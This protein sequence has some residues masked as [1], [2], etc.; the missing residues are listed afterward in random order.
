MADLGG[1]SSGGRVDGGVV[2][3]ELLPTEGSW[4]SRHDWTMGEGMTRADVRL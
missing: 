1:C 3:A 4:R 2:P